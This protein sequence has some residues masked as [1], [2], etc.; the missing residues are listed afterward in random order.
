MTPLSTRQATISCQTQKFNIYIVLHAGAFRRE[1][2]AGSLQY[3]QQSIRQ[4]QHSCGNFA[5]LIHR[6]FPP[7]NSVGT[8]KST[9]NSYRNQFMRFA[10]QYGNNPFH[11]VNANTSMQSLVEWQIDQ[12]CSLVVHKAQVIDEVRLQHRND[13]W[14]TD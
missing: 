2:E 6:Y 7:P 1:Y 12:L 11:Q 5:F 4:N 13:P 9:K 3:C 14:Q 10:Y 8:A